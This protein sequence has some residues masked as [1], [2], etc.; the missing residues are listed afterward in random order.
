MKRIRKLLYLATAFAALLLVM[1]CPTD[2]DEEVVLAP[3][4]WGTAGNGAITDLTVGATYV[5]VVGGD[6]SG[7]KG[8]TASGT[9]VDPTSAA[10]LR[11]GVTTITGLTNGT[12]YDVY[13]VV[14]GNFVDTTTLTAADYNTFV[15]FIGVVDGEYHTIAATAKPAAKYIIGYVGEALEAAT[16]GEINDQELEGATLDYTFGT[17]TANGVVLK[18][19]GD[20]WPFFILDLNGLSA[21]TFTTRI[22]VKT[23]D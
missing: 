4:S 14:H 7:I 23:A 1:A 2:D 3:G 17:T 16:G 20:G 6:I 9:L 19:I 13:K 5:V 22:T 18:N 11:S 21:D 8:V 15:D 12:T 10:P